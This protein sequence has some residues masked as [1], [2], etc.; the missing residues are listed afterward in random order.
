MQDTDGVDFALGRTMCVRER[1]STRDRTLSYGC[2]KLIRAHPKS[3]CKFVAMEAYK[4]GLRVE[5]RTRPY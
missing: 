3:L 1:S 4:K 2:H 5:M